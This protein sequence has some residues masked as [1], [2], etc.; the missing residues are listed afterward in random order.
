M[1]SV[2]PMIATADLFLRPFTLTDVPTVLALSRED[3]IRR[4]LPDQVYRDEAH[5]EQVVR[6]LIEHT[7]QADPRARPYVLGIE[8]AQ[9]KRLIGHIGL[10]PARASVEIGYAVE[11]LHQGRGF[12]PQAVIAMSRWALAELALPEL[13]GIV[14]A[15]N[16][17]SRRVLEKA[18]YK[19]IDANARPGD[20]LVFRQST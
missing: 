13:L 6:S 19:R 10:S 18:G 3:G 5:A 4:W 16:I 20:K 2:R 11:T 8:H 7:G 1:L 17:P 15:D 14:D 9:T 12:A